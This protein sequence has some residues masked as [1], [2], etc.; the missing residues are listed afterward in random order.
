MCGKVEHGKTYNSDVSTR[1]VKNRR[2]AIDTQLE[3]GV[4][5]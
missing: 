4:V 3:T 2:A 5:E 1:F